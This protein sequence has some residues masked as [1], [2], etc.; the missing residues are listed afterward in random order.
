MAIP[1]SA[2]PPPAEI[3]RDFADEV[4]RDLALK[5]KQIQSKYLYNGLGSALFEAICHLPWYR[6]TRAEGRLLARFAA[7]MVAPVGDPVTLTELGCGSGE[8][9]AMI[10][11]ALRQRRRPV[12]VHLIDISPSAL[13]LS[14]RTLGKFEHVSVV[15]HRAT[16][17]EGLRQAARDR[18]P[19]G[20]MLVLFLGSNI[21]NFD[22]P[23]AAE[24]LREIRQ[25]MRP[26]DALLLGAD[27]VK[28]ES[29]LLLAYDD[30]LGVTAAFN[31]NLL[32]RMNNEL[33]AD[34]DLGAFDHRAVWNARERRVEMHLVS[35]QAQTVRIPRADR[36]VSFAAGEAIWTESS[37][38]Y[39][40]DEIVDVVERGGFRCHEQWIEPEARFAL[41]LFLVG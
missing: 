5:P 37:Y 6:I 17:E 21:G 19:R 8:K 27:L 30:P 15:G 24:F 14:E 32:A 41:T 33:L 26:G 39:H 1:E 40:A 13:E 35:R 38:K 34:F 12:A 10:A 36:T 31:K 16:Y 22:P 9:L 3:V 11:E 20:A 18:P 29:E 7:E 4:R 25:T 2:Q 23:A 28:P